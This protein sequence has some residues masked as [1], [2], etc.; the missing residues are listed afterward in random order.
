MSHEKKNFAALRAHIYP[1]DHDCNLQCFV[2][3]PF[4]VF[5][6]TT[7]ACNGPP[8]SLD[9]NGL[10]LVPPLEKLLED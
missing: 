9:T 7:F 4:N 5:M 3:Q 2:M 10:W 8:V 1:V 6:Q